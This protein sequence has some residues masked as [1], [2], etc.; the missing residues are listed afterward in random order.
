ML[1]SIPFDQLLTWTSPVRGL[2]PAYVIGQSHQLAFAQAVRLGDAGVAAVSTE[3][4]PFHLLALVRQLLPETFVIVGADA[5]ELVYVEKVRFIRQ[6]ERGQSVQLL[7][8]FIEALP[9]DDGLVAVRLGVA[10]N[11][12]DEDTTDEEIP[13]LVGEVAILCG[14]LQ[15]EPATRP[16]RLI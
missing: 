12:T 2:S 11:T 14:N 13:L 9:D 3:I 6:A 8:T 4:E 10:L 7:A 5:Q 1:T 15:S 16:R